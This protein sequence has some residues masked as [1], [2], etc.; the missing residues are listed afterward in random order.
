[1]VCPAQRVF[2]QA[3]N[4]LIK[5]SFRIGRL[6]L[7]IDNP[8]D[9]PLL[10]VACTG[11]RLAFMVMGAL[12]AERIYSYLSSNRAS[13]SIWDGGCSSYMAA[14]FVTSASSMGFLLSSFAPTW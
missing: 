12:A 6:A 14:K 9:L 8:A 4:E 2:V 1:M 11:M 7:V 3:D 13:C 10:N 5:Q